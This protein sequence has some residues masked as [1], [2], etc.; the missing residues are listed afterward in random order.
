MMNL[1]RSGR[2]SCCHLDSSIKTWIQTLSGL[3]VV[4]YLPVLEQKVRRAGRRAWPLARRRQFQRRASWPNRGR[5][6]RLAYLSIE[7]HCDTNQWIAHPHNFEF[8]L[9]KDP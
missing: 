9:P 3:V 8:S 5:Q 1:L 4:G 2:D 6:T 7:L